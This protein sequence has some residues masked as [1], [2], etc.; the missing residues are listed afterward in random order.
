EHTYPAALNDALAAYQWLLDE[1][2]AADQLA[3]MGDSAGG[4]LTLSLVLELNARKMPLP[5][6]V[7]V[8][9]PLT[10]LDDVGDTQFTLADA[11][12][13]L[14]SYGSTM[15][16]LYAGDLP[17]DDPRVSPVYGDYAG[18]PPLLIQVGT[19]ERFLSDAARLARTARAANVDVTLDVWDGMWHVWQGNPELPEA[20]AASKELADFFLR[21]L[22]SE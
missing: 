1:G 17:L 21:H 19:R 5:S 14:R 22:D 3:V 13:V 12:P 8:L 16:G 11:D 20:E 15:Y 6:A 4:G 7:A 18:F 2:Y 9:S 10:D